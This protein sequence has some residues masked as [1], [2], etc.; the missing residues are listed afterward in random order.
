MY[1]KQKDTKTPNKHLLQGEGQH[2][3]GSLPQQ[4]NKIDF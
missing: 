4:C 1:A 2:I 3:Q